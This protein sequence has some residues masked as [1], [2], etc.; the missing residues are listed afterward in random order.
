MRLS[1]VQLGE[2]R[3][4]F[5]IRLKVSLQAVLAALLNCANRLLQALNLTGPL[6]RLIDVMLTRVNALIQSIVRLNCLLS[7]RLGLPLAH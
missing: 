1:F 4:D 5:L 7:L 3:G 2:Y 6:A